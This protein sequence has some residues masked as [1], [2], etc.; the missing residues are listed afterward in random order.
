[1]GDIQAL[2]YLKTVNFKEGDILPIIDVEMT[3][4]WTYSKYRKIYVNN[5]E[6]MVSTIYNKT[7]LTPIIYTT[8]MFWD[9]YISKYYQ[10][11]YD[12][13]LWVADYRKNDSPKIP[14]DFNDWVIWQHTNKGLTNG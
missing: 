3:K 11:K 13:I 8:E 7:G 6:K 5:L 4:H 1:P 14:K 10:N 2:H 12:H 9:A